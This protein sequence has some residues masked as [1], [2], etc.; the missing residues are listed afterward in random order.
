[1]NELI[2]SYLCVYACFSIWFL[3]CEL[4]ALPVVSSLWPR[5]KLYV[6]DHT[7]HKG[8]SSDYLRI[9]LPIKLLDD[10]SLLKAVF[11][12]CCL[13]KGNVFKCARC[14][15]VSDP[16]VLVFQTFNMDLPV[17]R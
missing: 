6:L 15:L 1:M 7:P 13:C 5:K 14:Y 8:G 2:A 12:F 9:N 10:F 16:H 3:V 17:F 11:K 4:S